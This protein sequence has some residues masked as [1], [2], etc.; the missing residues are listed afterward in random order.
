MGKK[1]HL[2]HP[3]TSEQGGALHGAGQGKLRRKGTGVPPVTQAHWARRAM[4]V[5]YI[6][7]TGGCY[8]Q[9]QM[10]RPRQ[11]NGSLALIK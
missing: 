10:R 1:S 9:V 8:P 7:R 4:L 11:Q 3:P 6:T 2:V 5:L